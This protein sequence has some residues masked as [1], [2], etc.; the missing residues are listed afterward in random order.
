M[1]SADI[2]RAILQTCSMF[3]EGCLFIFL[4]NQIKTDQNTLRYCIDELV[5]NKKLTVTVTDRGRRYKTKE[6]KK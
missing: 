2:N 3:K 1:K 4:R 6:I 5:K